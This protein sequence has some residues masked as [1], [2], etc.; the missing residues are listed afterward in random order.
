MKKF[1]KLWPIILV[2]L[3]AFFLRIYKLGSY[4][5]G[6]LWD[7][8]ALGYNA[9]SIL[10]TGRDEFGKFLPIIFKSFG[11]YKPGL[12]VYLTIPSILVFGLNEFAVRLPSALAGT[13]AVLISYLLIIE[14]SKIIFDKKLKSSAIALITA[15]ILAINPWHINFSRGAWELNLMLTEIL[16]G[17]FLLVKFL[18]SRKVF[19]LYLATLSLLSSLITYQAAKFLFPAVLAGFVWFYWKKIRPL[20]ARLKFNFLSI[21]LVGFTLV[22]LLTVIGGRAGRIKVMSIFSYPRSD[23]EKEMILNQDQQDQLVFRLFHDRPVFFLRSVLG[24]YFNHFSGRFL[25]ITG[26]WSNPRNGVIYQGVLYYLEII[27]LILGLGILARRKRNP[28]ENLML[29]WLIIAPL[30]SA[31]TRDNISSV[32]SFPMV[33][34]LVFIIAIGIQGSIDFLRKYSSI[35]QSSLF[36]ILLTSYLFFFIRFLDLYFVHNP[37]FN[38]QGHLYGYRQVMDFLLP[39]AQKKN[40]IIFSTTY[41]QPYIFW[42]FYSRYDP[43]TYQKKVIF[44]ENPYGDVGEIEKIGNFE[45]RKVYFPADRSIPNGLLVDDEF[46]L[47]TRDITSDE[48]KFNLIREINFLDGKVAFRVVETK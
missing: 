39:L 29:F 44:K 12:Y 36:I 10:K 5:V 47:P 7:E 33:I 42:L 16:L 41:G 18:N 9:Y 34:P 25:F 35:V 27:F 21:C 31:L 22:N 37:K 1:L 45:F 48:E 38:S 20:S 24:R 2:V 40:K 8:A 17:I 3:L 14:N 32:R 13:T 19:W 11:D 30:P 26:D 28:G 15:L 46:G 4:P 23:E 43:A 6:F